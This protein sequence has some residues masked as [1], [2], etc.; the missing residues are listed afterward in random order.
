MT[1]MEA[2][3]AVD[4]EAMVGG[5]S[6]RRPLTLTAVVLVVV[7]LSPLVANVLGLGYLQGSLTRTVI[8]GMAA[9]ALDFIVGYGGLVSLGHALFVGLGSYTTGVLLYNLSSGIGPGANQ[10]LVVLP[11]AMLVG[12]MLGFGLGALAL[13]TRGVYFIMVTL[14]FNQMMYFLFN[15]LEPYGGDD[16]VRLEERNHLGPL[17]LES[18]LVFFYVCFA[19]LVL[20]VVGFNIL[21]RSKFGWIL[22]GARDNDLRMRALGASTR[23]YQ[24]MAFVISASVASL[25]GA[26][27]VNESQFLSPDIA[28]WTVSGELL[29]MVIVGGLG[30]LIGGVIGS[31]ILLVL[32]ELAID[33]TDD[34]QF[35]VGIGLVLILLVA[36]NGVAGVILGKH[37]NV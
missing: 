32:E 10:A 20:V 23:R 8:L 24:L 17:S 11:L 12:A 35:F 2:T 34:W 18:D 31:G 1:Q 29:V 6:A 9:V 36:R 4:M 37:R 25:A 19:L 26:L 27:A 21:I 13:R 5:R 28:H 15:T 30:S 16:G 3:E 7:G 14:A 22:R 33:L